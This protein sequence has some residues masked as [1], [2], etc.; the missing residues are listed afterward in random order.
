MDL[1][2]QRNNIENIAKLIPP[3]IKILSFVGISFVIQVAVTAPLISIHAG[4]VI[5]GTNDKAVPTPPPPPPL[6]PVSI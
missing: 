2:A 3:H 4:A 6:Y 5:I 1:N